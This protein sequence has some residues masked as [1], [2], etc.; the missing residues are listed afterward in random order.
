MC[1]DTP[2]GTMHGAHR[3]LLSQDAELLS[4]NT[5]RCEDGRA[6][7]SVGQKCAG[8]DQRYDDRQPPS[9]QLHVL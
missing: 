3:T 9:E 2:G 7:H 1:S 6:L 4:V 5:D 8:D